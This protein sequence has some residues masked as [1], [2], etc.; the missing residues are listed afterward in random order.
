MPFPAISIQILS[1]SKLSSLSVREPRKHPPAQ[2][3]KLQASIEQFGFVLPI[4]IDAASRVIVG[5]GLALA[6]KKLG[7]PEV[8]AVTITDLDET[9]LRMLRLALNRLSEDLRWD[10]EALR[11]EFSDIMEIRSRTPARDRI[12]PALLFLRQVHAMKSLQM[13]TAAFQDF[14]TTP[15]QTRLARHL[16]TSPQDRVVELF[17]GAAR[18]VP[19]YR[20]FLTSLGIDSADVKTYA[21]FQTLPLTTTN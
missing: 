7:L 12:W 16:T 21:D 5:W 19:A 14:L 6:A 20:E 4:V 3:R 13:A 17:R 10:L 8:P 11:L 1:A 15:L 9:K 18:D 2:I